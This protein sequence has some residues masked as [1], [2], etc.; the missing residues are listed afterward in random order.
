LACCFINHH[1][2]EESVPCAAVAMVDGWWLNSLSQE[3]DGCLHCMLLR[4]LG[5]WLTVVNPFVTFTIMSQVEGTCLSGYHQFIMY[6]P[7]TTELADAMLIFTLLTVSL[8]VTL[9]RNQFPVHLWLWLD[10]L[11]FLHV[12]LVWPII[13]ISVHSYTTFWRE[14]CPHAEHTCADEFIQVVHLLATD[15]C[16]SLV[17]CR[18]HCHVQLTLIARSTDLPCWPAT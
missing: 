5:F 17:Q 13:S 15:H 3:D 2:L 1:S 12:T 9:W 6:S 11:S 18:F 4:L 10:D 14:H 7:G 16:S 8:T